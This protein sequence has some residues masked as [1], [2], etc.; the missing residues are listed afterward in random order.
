MKLFRFGDNGR[1]RAGVLLQDGRR[2]DVSNCGEDYCEQF[3][4]T[5]GP[6]RLQNW[7]IENANL[8]PIVHPSVRLGPCVAMPSKII[9]VGL[10]YA[11]HAAEAS[12]DVPKE[13]VIFLNA[14]SFLS[15]PNDNVVIPRN[16]RMTDWEVELAVIV[17]KRSSYVGI[18]DAMEHVSGYC[19]HN[20]YSEREF[21]LQ[22]GGNG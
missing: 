5:D 20:D 16:S 11:R 10:N 3:F 21:Q 8:C 14:T 19:L 18:D 12:M 15:G 17:G 2:I 22:R 1:E 7:I 13:P 6:R 4:A 9:C